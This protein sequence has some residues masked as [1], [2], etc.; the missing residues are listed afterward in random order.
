[1]TKIILSVLLS[2]GLYAS[3]THTAKV[4]ETL[5]SGGYSYIQVKEA[6]ENYWIAMTQ[7]SLKVGENISFNEQG[8]MH[9]FH[10]KTLDRTFDKILFASDTTEKAEAKAVEIKANVMHSPFKVKGTI[11]V[12]ELF[13][14]RNKYVGKK[15]QVRAKVTKTSESIMKRNW[16]HVQD[17]S[18][19]QNADDLVFTSSCVTPKTGSIVIAEGVVVKD[20]DFGYGYFYPVI[21]EEATFS[22]SLQ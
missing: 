12:A 5:N 11:T 19:F 2:L 6:D 4:I 13:K 1:M 20:K 17:G 18:R 14:N 21:V 15:V 10:S 22:K 16:V 8:W 7:R 9:K 3:S